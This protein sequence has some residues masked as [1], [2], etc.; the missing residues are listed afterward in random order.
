MTLRQHWI[1]RIALFSL[2]VFMRPVN[3]YNHFTYIEP[4]TPRNC[5]AFPNT[6]V[7]QQP[8]QTE[9]IE[10]PQPVF[11]FGVAQ[12]GNRLFCKFPIKNISNQFVLV[13]ARTYGG[14]CRSNLI[15]PGQVVFLNISLLTKNG[16]GRISKPIT[17]YPEAIPFPQCTLA[18]VKIF[19]KWWDDLTRDEKLR[20]AVIG[21]LFYVRLVN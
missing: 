11:D 14:N 7:N 20:V 2:L 18:P 3:G 16:T 13:Q 12:G 10:C 15:L 9:L 5:V 19:V 6:K 1:A 21:N 17:L 8:I 4:Q